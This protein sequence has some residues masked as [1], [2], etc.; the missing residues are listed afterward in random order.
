MVT[1]FNFDNPFLEKYGLYNYV[2]E[3]HVLSKYHEEL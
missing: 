3:A 1:S 2:E